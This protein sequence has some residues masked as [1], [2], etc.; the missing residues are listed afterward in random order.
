MVIIN[1]IAILILFFSFVG[2]FIQGAVKSFFSLLALVIAIPIAGFFYPSMANLLSFLHSQNW[3]NFIGFFIILA[4]TSIV[5]HFIFY[6]PRKLLEKIEVKGILWRSIGG[7]LN[8][9]GSAIGL[10]VFA[11]VIS[12]YPVWSWLQESFA[13]S[14]VI[15][16]LVSNL[17]F[18]QH[19]LPQIMRQPLRHLVLF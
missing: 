10:V 9:V 11:S 13:G 18:V 7:I 14:G 5:L 15:T 2:G 4:L 3:S 12:A 8:L 16:W 19:L 17:G 6:L 1:I